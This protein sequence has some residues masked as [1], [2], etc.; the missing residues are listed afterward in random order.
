MSTRKLI[1][2]VA[3][4]LALGLAGAMAFS[5]PPVALADP[6]DSPFAGNW[7]GTFESNQG[8]EGTVAWTFSEAGRLTGTG[9]NT[10]LN[11]SVEF[12]GHIGSDG[13]LVLEGGGAF[14]GTAVINDDG[15]LVASTTFVEDESLVVVATLDPV[16]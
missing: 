1:S 6:P 14:L 5:N 11:I 16:P 10:V 9:V 8:H 12:V 2:A 7:A 3:V 13:R 4:V 15:Q